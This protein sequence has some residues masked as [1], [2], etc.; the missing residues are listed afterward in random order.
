MAQSVNYTTNP[1]YGEI[2]G[3]F[4]NI[5]WERE[6]SEKLKPE[7]KSENPLSFVF[8]LGD[9]DEEQPLGDVRSIDQINVVQDREERDNQFF[10]CNSGQHEVVHGPDLIASFAGAFRLQSPC[11]EEGSCSSELGTT[12]NYCPSDQDREYA[13]ALNSDLAGSDVF[14]IT[15]IEVFSVVLLLWIYLLKSD[16]IQYKLLILILN[17]R[18]F[19]TLISNIILNYLYYKLI[20]W[21]KALLS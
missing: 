21:L 8:Y 16:L 1:I 20:G 10:P 12:R 7:P 3:G 14:S 6:S 13:S 9:G 11:N 2:F 17:D 5:P 15:E 4:T 19:S 18:L